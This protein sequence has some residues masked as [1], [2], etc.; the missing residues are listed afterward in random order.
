MGKKKFDDYYLGLDIGTNSVGWAVTDKNY[1]IP[2]FNG[3]AMWGVHLFDPGNT[4][5]DRRIQRIARRRLERRKQRIKLLQK[6]FADEMNSTD[7]DFFKRLNESRFVIEDRTHKNHDTLF[8]DPS[9]KDRDLFQKYPTI[10]H[11]R[12]NLME[13]QNEK[14]DI[15]L[16]YLACHHIIKYRG[17]FLFE[18]LSDE[19]VPEFEIVFAEL[20][21]DLNQDYDIEIKAESIS[22]DVKNI[23]SD[24]NLGIQEKKKKLQTILFDDD[25]PDLLKELCTL[26]SGGTAN[27][28]KMFGENDENLGLGKLTFKNTDFDE[29]K[30]K[31]EDIIPNE[32]EI[33]ARAKTIYDWT[34][35]F[36]LLNEYRSISKSK[37]AG[38]GQHAA[39][40][41]LL[42]SILKN[43]SEKYKEVFKSESKTLNNYPAYAG[44]HHRN[45]SE[46][47][48][49]TQSDFCAYLKKLFKE[50]FNDPEFQSNYADMIKRI[51]DETF[52]PKQTTTDNSLFP[53]AL[54][55]Q[56]LRE[57]LNNMEIYYPFLNEVD[58]T[59][60]SAK[61]KI[62]MLC[63]FRIPYY[64]GPLNQ[65]SER[66][67]VSR[68]EG[69]ITPWNF[70]N[71]VNLDESAHNFMERLIGT[72]T[73]IPSEKVLP[74]NSLI[75]QRY[76][77]YNELNP[78]KINGERL[79]ALNPKLKNELVRDLFENPKSKKV[80]K[81]KIEEYLKQKNLLHADDEV[82]MSGT[83]DEIK[84]SLKSEAQLKAILG[85]DMDYNMAENVIRSLTVFGD[86]KSRIIEKFQKEY[87]EKL[88]DDQIKKLSNLRF[89]DWGR[90]SGKF[91]TNVYSSV[92]GEET[93][94][95][96]ALETTDKNLME[97]LSGDYGFKKQIDELNET[98]LPAGQITYDLVKDLYVSPAVRRGIWRSLRI[99]EDILKITG[100][101][102]AK[103]FIE[104]T[105]ENQESK[106]T[107][108]RKDGLVRL[109][110]ACKKENSD[111]V[112]LLND[113]KNEDE[114]RLRGKDLYAYYTQQGKCMYCGKPI[115]LNDLGNNALYDLD[116]IHPRSKKTD[117]SIHNN[118]VLVCKEHNQIKSDKYPLPE[119][120]QKNM[121]SFWSGLRK[122]GFINEE[123][124]SRLT[125]KHE[126]TPDELSGFINRQLV[127]T[128]QSVKAVAET[129]K[130]VFDDNTDIVY[131]KANA[132]SDFR[133]GNNGFR[134]PEN[135]RLKFIKCRS[136]NDFHHA[137]DAYLN[138]VVGNVYDTKFTKDY[139]NF[140]QSGE[141]YNLSR[142]FDR[143]VERNGVCAWNAQKDGKGGTI[144]TVQ[145]YMRRN[146]ILFTRFAYEVSG[147]L[148]DLNP[149]KKGDGQLPLK[150]GLS[151]DKYGGY[152]NLTGSYYS[153]VEHTKNKKRIKTIQPVLLHF[154]KENADNSELVKYMEN[155]GLENPRI[156]IGKI[157]KFS[158]F[159]IDGFKAHISGRT[160]DSYVY[161]GA[162]QLILSETDYTYC[163]K[164]DNYV[165]KSR[166]TKNPLSALNYGLSAE[167]NIS[168]YDI[169]I[170]KYGGQ[171]YHI[172]FE[173]VSKTLHEKRDNFIKLST[174]D[175][176]K[177]LNE[178]LHGF[179]CNA[180]YLNLEKIGGPKLTGRITKSNNISNFD[181]IKLI[182]QSP[183]G[184]FEK[185]INLKEL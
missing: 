117:D 79:F 124:Y 149:V 166:E 108:S 107:I 30:A 172:I 165:I 177:V 125:R 13:K 84:S 173:T 134:G 1:K 19:A 128:S 138:I 112:N 77:L 171:K 167:E 21:E 18:G 81:K 129:L 66:S 61:D 168:L 130:K 183:T 90:L 153:L 70:E 41:K 63:T 36:N 67:W 102:P 139:K 109:Y 11:L 140:I 2:N 120:W 162:E 185:E 105:R 62:L 160:G 55:K 85:P 119:P 10:Y 56:E 100:H 40:L 113:L 39:D 121:G 46:T 14:P 38:Y 42:K 176:T 97:L 182:H 92:N 98:N 58:E 175:Q 33:L 122:T 60:F 137:K 57:I 95:L 146:N 111:L 20:L 114:G 145:K 82:E 143:D 28:D 126:F 54:H 110:E 96:K 115:D 106:R 103:V 154:S 52:M 22:G 133:N 5:E 49:C 88:T 155:K 136:V 27:L 151:I 72:C 16:L 29:E 74:K 75:Y 93:N 159:E 91:L 80:T 148:F 156:L 31:W 12:N 164:I 23:L 6:I 35:L 68:E 59:G 132:V 43:E 3:K 147:S 45:A 65:K 69:E 174:D 53:N 118:L 25:F 87:S 157:L 152:N 7:S 142:M 47:N 99:V 34:L 101:A 44:V 83:D 127:E 131:V 170:E 64:V 135:E 179:Q 15:R 32:S 180:V 24:K 17:H 76:M 73:Y 144:Q 178:I 51:N 181:S 116:H 94:I 158:M 123:K 8:N 4:A 71:K 141:G 169:F 48:S 104:T 89:K 86:D 163:K 150:K 184:L 78:L 50:E 161:Y 37:I 9:F 26:I